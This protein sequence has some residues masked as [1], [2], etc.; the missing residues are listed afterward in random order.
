MGIR[1]T[2]VFDN[3]AARKWVDMLIYLWDSSCAMQTL[4]AVLYRMISAARLDERSKSTVT[5]RANPGGARSSHGNTRDA[6]KGKR[7]GPAG[8]KKTGT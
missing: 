2:G 1:G 8:P 7:T 6:Q 3:E 4:A 5:S